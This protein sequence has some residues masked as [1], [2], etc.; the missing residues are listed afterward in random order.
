MAGDVRRIASC[1]HTPCACTMSLS[2]W[3][4]PQPLA[5]AVDLVTETDKQ[6][7]ALIM[8]HISATYPSH[9]FIGEE[10]SSVHGTARL[11]DD[12]TWMVDPLDGTT[13]FVHRYPFVCV[14]IGLAI[15][16]AVVVGVVFNPI[17]NE[18]FT[19]M[20]GHGAMLNDEPIHASSQTH[21]GS[22]LLA[23]EIGTKRDVGTVAGLTGRITNLLFQLR[24]LRL[25]GSCALNL[26]GVACGRLDLFY[27]IGFGGPLGCSS[28]VADSGGGGRPLLRPEWRPI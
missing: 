20:R 7:E 22:A 5:C 18:M 9:K 10:E 23:T 3:R 4:T 25:S 16:K 24:S 19:A 21:M 28:G 2:A 1:V 12:P 26:V 15:S 27:E 14:S 6:C 13:N 17:L 11:S 8:Q